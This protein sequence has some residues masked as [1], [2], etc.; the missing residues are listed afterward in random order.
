VGIGRRRKLQERERI[1]GER[2]G[3]RYVER[4]RS[5]RLDVRRRERG[6]KGLEDP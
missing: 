2:E 3:R 4:E 1:G 6:E 5:E